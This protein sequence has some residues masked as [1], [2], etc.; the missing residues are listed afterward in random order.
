MFLFGKLFE[1]SPNGIKFVHKLLII[2]IRKHS[3]IVFLS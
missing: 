3:H 2:V 1:N